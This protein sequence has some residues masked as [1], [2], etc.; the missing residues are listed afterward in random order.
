MDAEFAISPDVEWDNPRVRNIKDPQA[1]Q[2]EYAGFVANAIMLPKITF[3]DES[4]EDTQF[5]IRTSE[6]ELAR[7]SSFAGIAIHF[8]DTYRRKLEELQPV[9]AAKP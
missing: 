6:E 3:A 8:Y 2:I 9:T 5:Q 7:Y 1:G 4:A